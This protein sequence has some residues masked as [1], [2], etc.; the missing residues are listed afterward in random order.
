MRKDRQHRKRRHD[1]QGEPNNPDIWQHAHTRAVDYA[2]QQPPHPDG[3]QEN[4]RHSD[5]QSFSSAFPERLGVDRRRRFLPD[6]FS[7]ALSQHE[8]V[9]SYAVKFRQRDE[10]FEVGDGLPGIT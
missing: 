4:R 9:K 10:E 6:G 3:K 7:A 8:L 2:A 5:E 1:G